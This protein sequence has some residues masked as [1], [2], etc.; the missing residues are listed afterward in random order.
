MIPNFDYTQLSKT[1]FH[2]AINS[3]KIQP[4]TEQQNRFVEA[5]AETQKKNS[6]NK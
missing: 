6:K 1:M 3:Q 5:L 4:K 2:Y